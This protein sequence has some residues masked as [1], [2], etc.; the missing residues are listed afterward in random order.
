MELWYI[1]LVDGVFHRT[2]IEIQ[3]MT[4]LPPP[5]KEVLEKAAKEHAVSDH[6]LNYS[7]LIPIKRHGNIIPIQGDVTSRDS[8]LSIVSIIG[9]QTGYINLLVNNSGVFGPNVKLPPTT[10][11]IKELQ[12]ILWEVTPQ[13]FQDT[14]EVN[15]T[16]VYY[17]T[18]AFLALLDKGNKH[19]GI[20]GVTSQVVTVSSIAGFRRDG[21]VTGIAYHTSKAA[22]THLGKVLAN[23]LKDWNIRSN[24]IAPGIYPSGPF[25]YLYFL[26]RLDNSQI[27]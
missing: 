13:A 8:L 1:L 23:L 12:N 3:Q 25:N 11:D 20:P 10:S 14:F 24:I 2:W 15:V 19:G 27:P 22:V 5:S 4:C 18:V 26:Y 9:S 16:A 7:N 21:A 6:I 17:T